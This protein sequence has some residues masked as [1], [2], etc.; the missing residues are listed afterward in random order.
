M[1]VT[2]QQQKTVKG[3]III[4]LKM[5]AAGLLVSNESLGQMIFDRLCDIRYIYRRKLQRSCKTRKM[6]LTITT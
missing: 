2:L 4:K 5:C 1:L 3:Q 6:I